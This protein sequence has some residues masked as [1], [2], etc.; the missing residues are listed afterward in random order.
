MAEAAQ[1]PTHSSQIS[2][3]CI[4]LAIIF[5]FWGVKS[6]FSIVLPQVIFAEQETEL[7]FRVLNMVPSC[8]VHLLMNPMSK[9][10][11]KMA[12]EGIFLLHQQLPE[13]ILWG[14]WHQ[15]RRV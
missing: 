5:Y 3:M 8:L 2:M 12:N 4:K 10:C 9:S 14:F 15:L 6:H 11:G 1:K 13:L 7:T